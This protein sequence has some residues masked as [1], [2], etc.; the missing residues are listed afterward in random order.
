MKIIKE[1]KE[2]GYTIGIEDVTMCPTVSKD[3]KT[4]KV[5]F[6]SVEDAMTEYGVTLVEKYFKECVRDEKI[7]TIIK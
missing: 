3:G 5:S 7:D 2:K 6:V 4:I 1:L